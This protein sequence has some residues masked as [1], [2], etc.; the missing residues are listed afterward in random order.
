[1]PTTADVPAA[2]AALGI[3]APPRVRRAADL[4][5]FAMVWRFAR[6]SGPIT[7]DGTR[8]YDPAAAPSTDATRLHCYSAAGFTDE[9]HRLTDTDPTIQL[10]DA[11]RLYQGE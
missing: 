3:P 9:L 10:I 8:R 7:V 11:E 5:E 2:A 4:P 1:M 6:A